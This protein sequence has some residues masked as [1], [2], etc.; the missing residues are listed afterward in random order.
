MTIEK[1]IMVVVFDIDKLCTYL[2]GLKMIVYV[3][4]ADIRYLLRKKGI[5]PRLIR[6]IL[7]P[8]E[9]NIEIRDKKG[10][11]NMVSDHLSRLTE[12]KREKLHFEESFMGDKLFVL[13]QKETPW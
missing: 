13:V 3:V 6:W 5:K 1:E 9:F 12:H 2:V 4:H 8:Q 10:I 11:E 7:L